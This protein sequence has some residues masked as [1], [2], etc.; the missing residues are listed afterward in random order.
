MFYKHIDGELTVPIL[1][2]EGLHTPVVCFS[3]F[4][5]YEAGADDIRRWYITPH[6]PKSTPNMSATCQKMQ[7][8]PSYPSKITCDSSLYSRAQALYNEL[9]HVI[10]DGVEH[11]EKKTPVLTSHPC[12]SATSGR[13]STST[14]VLIFGWYTEL[15][16]I[17][18]LQQNLKSKLGQFEPNL[19][20]IEVW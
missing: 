12:I 18:S 14:Y 6:H 7:K 16:V 9:S 20:R 5:D 1:M 11:L 13:N 19:E 10:F 3:R 4:R 8:P 17:D 2:M 15:C